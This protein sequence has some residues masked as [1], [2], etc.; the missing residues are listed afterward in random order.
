[1]T[2]L[3]CSKGGIEDLSAERFRAR[4]ALVS[5]LGRE[6]LAAVEVRLH[7]VGEGVGKRF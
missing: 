1:M 4:E 3:N 5:V 2:L 7:D 6:V